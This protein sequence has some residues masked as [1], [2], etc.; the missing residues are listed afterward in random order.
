VLR[1]RFDKK[2]L[3]NLDNILLAFV[4]PRS[5]EEWSLAYCQSHIYVEYLIKTYG[6][7]SVGPM[8]NAF[9][10]GLDTA[11]AL[12]KVC[13]VDKDA[14]EKGYMGYVTEIV[15]AIP[16]AVKKTPEKPMTLAELEKA[17]EKDP[18]DLEVAARLADQYSRRKRAAD[19][20]KLAEK[21]LEAKPG[22][23]TA[24]IVKARLLSLAGDDDGARDVIEA[25]AKANPDDPKL[26][27]A[28]GRMALE[29]KDWSKAAEIFEKG[30]KASPIDGDWLPV[31]IEIYTKIEDADKLIEV[32]KEQVGN[33]PDDLKSRIKLAQL[34]NT[35]KK[36]A[37]AEKI[38]RD[39]IY[40]DVTNEEA[41]K[42]LVES[43]EGQK[44]D[45]EVET[46]KKR[47]GG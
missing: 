12:R 20:R 23:P 8:L 1:D 26:M 15:K 34:L 4:R 47:F 30:R 42:V 45:A 22:H 44:K 33:D 13:K 17:H 21:V 29:N 7:E 19:S 2:E 36:Y 35:A 32:L 40:I 11:G 28:L 25:A 9:R 46:L 38:A 41:Q 27:L 37:D 43:L 18:D 16:S 24:S 3:L 39:A 10:E 6:I 31:L 5:Q 14:F